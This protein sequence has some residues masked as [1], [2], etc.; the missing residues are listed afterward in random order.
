M[1]AAFEEH[2]KSLATPGTTVVV[3]RLGSAKPVLLDYKSRA[4]Q[5]LQA[6]FEASFGQR[7]VLERSGGTVPV[8]LPFAEHVG[9]ELVASGLSQA[10]AGPHGPNEHFRLENLPRGIATLLRFLYTLS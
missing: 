3:K 5:A 9:G 6:A 8:A 4:S 1:F 2:V 10:G 7:A